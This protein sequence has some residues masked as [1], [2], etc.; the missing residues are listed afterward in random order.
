[1]YRYI[2]KI[3]GS[4]RFAINLGPGDGTSKLS[5]N[6]VQFHM[7]FNRLELGCVRTPS[8]PVDCQNAQAFLLD[9]LSLAIR[10]DGRPACRP[11]GRA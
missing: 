11:A 7:A 10:P 1:M 5:S 9:V 4:L 2:Y 6:S 3:D 8:L